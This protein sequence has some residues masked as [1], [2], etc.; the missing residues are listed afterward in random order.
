MSDPLRLATWNVNS[1]RARTDRVIEFLRRSDVD[2]LAIQETKVRDDGFPVAAISD[3]GYQVAHHGLNQ[4][5]GVAVLSRVGLDDVQVGF[6]GMPG[7]GEPPATEARALS[8]VCGGVRVWSVYVPNGREIE[9]PHY[10]YKLA[11]LEALARYGTEA[12]AA[13]PALQMAFC[14]DYNIAPTDADVWSVDYYLDKTH[15]T[16][17]ERA[18]FQAVVDAGYADVVR[19]YTS[20]PRT[21]TYWDYQQLRFPKNRG[22]R[23]DFVLA[24]AALAARVTSAR[25]DREERKGKGASDHA[26]VIV[27]FGG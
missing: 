6:P 4:W 13:D 10:Q 9:H 11:W 16:P 23:I 14:G 1:I 15:T 7:Y 20:E 17:P 26:P 8:A 19:P 25:I 27:E 18:A 22:M 24:S 21:F 2:V 12:L 5:N 3:L